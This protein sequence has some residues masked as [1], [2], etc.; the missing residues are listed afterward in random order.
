MYHEEDGLDRRLGFAMA[1]RWLDDRRPTGKGW[2]LNLKNLFREKGRFGSIAVALGVLFGLLLSRSLM[3]SPTYGVVA[4][5]GSFI[6]ALAVLV[7]N[8]TYLVFLW[9]VLTSVVYLVS[10][11]L[12]VEGQSHLLSQSI[13]WGILACVIVAWAIEG[14]LQRRRFS[15][16]PDAGL[17]YIL[18]FFLGWA[19]LS[20]SSSMDVARSL[21]QWLHIIVALMASYMFYDWF[22]VDRRNIDKVVG[23]LFWVTAAISVA[24]CAMALDGL[25]RGVPIYKRITLWFWNANS[26]G[27]LLFVA[28]PIIASS[29]LPH[30]RQRWAK[31]AVLTVLLLA[32][33]ASFSRTSWLGVAAATAFL[34]W[35]GRWRIPMSIIFVLAFVV[36]FWSAIL[37]GYDLLPVNQLHGRL[38]LWEAAWKVAAEH[39]WLGV[40][41]GNA[42][43]A[44]SVFIET[45]WLKGQAPHSLYLNNA[46]EIGFLSV[47]FWGLFLV[48]YLYSTGKIERHVRSDNL[49]RLVRGARATIVGLAFH[50]IFENGS[51]LTS[52]MAA[53]FTV[54]LP[55]ILLAIPFSAKQL[56]EKR[57][58][59]R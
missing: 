53:E 43:R 4:A 30:V 12:Y 9:F 25:I 42:N 50:G 8:T 28:F 26:L 45:P 51:V 15:V 49:R 32:I 41:L 29:D 23:A 7:R 31:W 14:V 40:G 35:Q 16:L 27:Y 39:P 37:F 59:V 38:E 20:I 55:Y 10:S 24:V 36:Y 11:P 54:I 3:H 34:L 5:A 22:S 58:N 56:E 13:F 48:R 21:K 17:I 1:Y 18:L 46:S 33:L 19:L 52:F 6:L 47:I 57:Q 44:M 2:I